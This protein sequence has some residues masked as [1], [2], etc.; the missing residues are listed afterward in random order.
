MSDSDVLDPEGLKA[1][2]DLVGP[3]MPDIA[4][5]IVVLYIDSSADAYAQMKQAAL[6]GDAKG[7]R[8][9]SHKIKGSTGNVGAHLVGA[10]AMA[11]E[12]ASAA[13][14]PVPDAVD[15]RRRPAFRSIGS[16]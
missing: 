8:E 16:R 15:V 9:M 13:G 3:D 4:K 11:I 1:L 2:R 7:V 14:D 10:Q 6:A 5:E 12:Q